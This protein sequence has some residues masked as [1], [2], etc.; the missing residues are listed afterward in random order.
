MVDYFHVDRH[1]GGELGLQVL[2]KA[3]R[4]HNLRLIMDFVPNHVH[5]THPWFQS[6]RKNKR[7]PYRDWFYWLRDGDYLKYLEIAEL[8]KLNLDHPAARAEVIRAAMHWLELGIDGFR[9]DHALGPSLDF[10]HEFRNRLKKQHAE[11]ALVGEVYFSGIQ[12]HSLPTLRLPDKRWYFLAQQLG[13]D[14]LE[15][16]MNEYSS[17]FDGLLDFHFQKLL[18]EFL[19]KAERPCSK[20]ELQLRLDGHYARFP[21][22]CALLSFLDNHDMNRFLF[23]A[24]NDQRRLRQ[25]IELQFAQKNPPVIYYGTERGMSQQ[26]GIAGDHGDLQARRQMTWDQEDRGLFQF[27]Q[28]QIKVW[29]ARYPGAT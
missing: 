25:A 20:G 7:S 6:A 9:L 12:R 8:P 14:V 13:F 1:F 23:E 24:G 10:W 22:N 17:V 4:T 3:A 27:Y 16:T 29:K 2:V 11:V 15:G 19:A 26:A 5:E 28:R 21:E 18:R